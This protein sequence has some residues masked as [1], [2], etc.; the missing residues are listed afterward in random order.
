MAAYFCDASGIA[1]RYLH[2]TGTPWVQALV[3]PS[4]GKRLFLAR[5]TTVEVVSAVTRRQRGG[6]L[7][8]AE[9]AAILTQFRL[10]PWPKPMPC[11]LTT[12]CSWLLPWTSRPAAPPSACRRLPCS[13]PT[14]I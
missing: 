10:G 12:P 13:Q 6:H 4:A 5:I 3:N 8:L 7:S 11:A 2:E 14:G 9:A 1:K